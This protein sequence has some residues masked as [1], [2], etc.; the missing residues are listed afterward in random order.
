[1][2]LP[3]GDCTSYLGTCENMNTFR[4]AAHA[5]ET[6]PSRQHVAARARAHARDSFLLLAAHGFLTSSSFPRGEM[7]QALPISAGSRNGHDGTSLF[8]GTSASSL[9]PIS[10]SAG[11]PLGTSKWE[12]FHPLEPKVC[13]KV[14]SAFPRVRTAEQRRSEPRRNCC[15]QKRCAR[16]RQRRL[17]LPPSPSLVS[18]CRSRTDQ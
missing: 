14:S 16:L 11:A 17:H 18:P 7:G 10:L 4:A 9:E 2:C 1:M 5:H 8:P 13:P 12:K 15:R 3:L 6:R